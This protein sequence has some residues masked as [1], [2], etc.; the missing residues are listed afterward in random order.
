MV[1]IKIILIVFITLS[2]LDVFSQKL[3]STKDK[4]LFNVHVMD[5]S[6]RP[7]ANER[8]MLEGLNSKKTFTGI[9][10][11]KGLY[12]VLI[13]KGDKYKI[14][15]KEFDEFLDYSNLSVPLDSGFFTFE[16]NIRFEH[17]E[18]Y[19]LKNVNFDSDK[20]TLKQD[21]YETL[22]QL[23]DLMKRQQA[24]KIEVAGHTDNSG[25]AENNLKLS[26]DRAK[27]VKNYLVS[28]GIL[29]TRITA[30]GYGDTE[31]VGDNNTEEGKLANRRTEVRIIAE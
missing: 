11:S 20:S 19:T 23:V 29:N 5:L 9:S 8:I 14:K 26:T 4:V 21:S 31:P 15:Y 6:N 30:S 16:I 3:Q 7:R 10:N 24:I 17:Q 13:P 2:F 1:K 28:K 18:T 22:N 25:L 27:S 12:S